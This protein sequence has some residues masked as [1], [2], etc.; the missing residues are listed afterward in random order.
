[1]DRAQLETKLLT[2]LM[3]RDA[4]EWSKRI[5]QQYGKEAADE[6]EVQTRS[7][8]RRDYV[9]TPRELDRQRRA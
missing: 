8:E 6:P 9:G 5:Q 1:M 4:R 3:T 7:P 2:M